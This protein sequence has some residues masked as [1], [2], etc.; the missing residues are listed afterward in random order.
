MLLPGNV[1]SVA[2]DLGPHCLLRPVC[3]NTQEKYGIRYSHSGLWTSKWTSGH[4]HNH[5]MIKPYSS[6]Q[7][8]FFVFFLFCLKKKC[9]KISLFFHK[10]M[11]CDKG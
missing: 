8:V 7:V 1:H 2:S 3:P 10:N 9:L 5:S 11:I 6:I 4:N